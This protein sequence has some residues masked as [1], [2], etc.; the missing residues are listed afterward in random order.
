MYVGMSN[1][2]LP[3]PRPPGDPLLARLE[4][5]E[6]LRQHNGT[7]QAAT[8]TATQTATST[9]AA[10]TARQFAPPMYPR[11][12]ARPVGKQARRKKPA[13]IAKLGALA[14]SCATTGGLVY[15]FADI[16]TT[17]AANQ[18]LA[19]L[20]TAVP[21]TSAG[22]TPATSTTV[23]A[24]PG[25]E[26]ATT[27]VVPTT[28]AVPVMQA[29]NGNVIDTRYGPVQVQ[30]QFTNGTISEVAVIAYPDGDSE[31]V[32]IN[33]RALPTLRTEVLTAQSAQIDTVSGATYT[34]NAYKKSLQSAIDQARAAGVTAIS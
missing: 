2:Q 31:S 33:A 4:R 24:T 9:A 7:G 30:V 25:V 29:Y 14:L 16:N 19:A 34:T 3:P 12:T 6:R 5:L 10:R 23:V 15:L 18:A 21:I 13:R 17:Q 1:R 8:S 28:V 27:V 20:P 22:A 26:P 11:Q 32:R